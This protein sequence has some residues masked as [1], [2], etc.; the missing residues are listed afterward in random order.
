ME[1]QSGTVLGLVERER[2]YSTVHEGALYLHLGESYLVRELDLRARAA[3][4]TP[5]KG[6]YYT[7]AKKDT[8][9]AIEETLRTER[10]CG[11]ELC[12]ACDS[13]QA[14][15][16]TYSGLVEV[17]VGLIPGGA[18]TMNM[19]GGIFNAGNGAYIGDFNTGFFNQSGGV[20][21]VG[22][23]LYIGYGAS[24]VGTC[25]PE[26]VS[27]QAAR[28]VGSGDPER[29]P[30]VVRRYIFP[31]HT[32]VPPLHELGVEPLQTMLPA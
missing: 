21:N 7:Q 26:D 32:G 30:P 23:F 19:T 10:R 16:E 11:L 5:Y 22:S 8:N 24:T 14:A 3:V 17:G 1:A 2:A 20:N 13:V 6:D 29:A 18:G 28:L 4:V 12:F 27:P 9:T 15:A 25:N 31:T